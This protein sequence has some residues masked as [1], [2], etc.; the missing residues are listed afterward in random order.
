MSGRHR[1]P[2]WRNLRWRLRNLLDTISG[3]ADGDDWQLDEDRDRNGLDVQLMGH[4]FD[5][6]PDDY[7]VD[8]SGRHV[9]KVWTPIG[10]DR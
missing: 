9:R 1:M 10:G 2:F 8:D 4:R 7:A 5:E 6:W 3:R